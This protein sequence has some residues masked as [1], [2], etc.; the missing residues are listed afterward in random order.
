VVAISSD[1]LYPKYLQQELVDNLPNAKPLVEID[2]DYGH[3][4]FLL[5]VS[6]ISSAI[7]LALEI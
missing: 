2:S 3:D 1:R 7:D 5:E 6:G 4:A